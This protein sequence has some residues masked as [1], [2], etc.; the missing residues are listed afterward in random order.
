MICAG[1]VG[2]KKGDFMADYRERVSDLARALAGDDVV[3]QR[4]LLRGVR[5]LPPV[6]VLPVLLEA[7]VCEATDA[8]VCREILALLAD[9]HSEALIA[10]LGE[11]LAGELPSAK[12][13]GLLSI[14]W[15]NRMDFSPLI[16]QMLES[17]VCEDLLVVNEAVT[18]L[19]LA[20]EHASLE[21]VRSTLRSLREMEREELPKESVLFIR[22]GITS[23]AQLEQRIA[24]ERCAADRT[25]E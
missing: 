9:L 19:E 16:P 12:R 24:N 1:W 14:C 21:M 4:E 22:E 3:A 10:A 17:L 11:A 15:Q 25:N 23:V 13:A 20:L 2:L 6:E 7:Y 8:A 18:S 5:G